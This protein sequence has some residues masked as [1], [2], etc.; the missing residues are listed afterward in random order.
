MAVVRLFRRIQIGD[1]IAIKGPGREFRQ[2]VSSLVVN[3]R[4]VEKASASKI[5]EMDVLGPVKAGDVVSKLT[6]DF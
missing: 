1:A 4:F 2:M 6:G 5:V 3:G